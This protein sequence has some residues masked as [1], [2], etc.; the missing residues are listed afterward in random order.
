MTDLTVWYQQ[1]EAIARHANGWCNFAIV[2]G[3]LGF[4]LSVVAAVMLYRQI[5]KEGKD[6]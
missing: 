3:I 1:I 6:D 5:K 2:C 4:V